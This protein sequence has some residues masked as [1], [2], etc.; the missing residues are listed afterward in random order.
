[1]KRYT[2]T[3]EQRRNKSAGKAKQKSTDEFWD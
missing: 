3:A 2:F 1:M